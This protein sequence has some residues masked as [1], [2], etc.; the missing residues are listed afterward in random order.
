MA[1]E[2]LG[3]YM[4]RLQDRQQ[5]KRVSPLLSFVAGMMA[6]AFAAVAFSIADF[7]Y[8]NDTGAKV[9]QFKEIER[10]RLSERT[11]ERPIN[12]A[13]FPTEPF[14]RYPRG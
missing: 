13:P 10:L 14:P 2:S 7:G 8:R 1:Q 12:P 9:E 11:Q 4:K 6:V 5:R 3:Q